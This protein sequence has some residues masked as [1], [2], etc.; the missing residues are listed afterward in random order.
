MI[1]NVLSRLAK[2]GL[3]LLGVSLILA[4]TAQAQS[5]NSANIA[6]SANP[7]DT[8][9]VESFDTGFHREVTVPR[10]GKYRLRSLPTGSYSVVIQRADG[11]VAAS[12]NVTLQVGSTARVDDPAVKNSSAD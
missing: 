6:G 10:S 2:R 3:L 11:S 12:S 4:A 5:N 8:I 1:R 7:G 9:I